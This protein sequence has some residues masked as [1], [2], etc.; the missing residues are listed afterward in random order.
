MR[1]DY[2]MKPVRVQRLLGRAAEGAE[3]QARCRWR[4]CRS[5]RPSR[6]RFLSVTER[7][8]VVLV[9]LD[10]IVYLKAELKYI[11]IRYGAAR[12]PARGSR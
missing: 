6:A 3:A 9:P 5:C 10:D 4:S 2:L 8:R 12:V 11:T 1:I 7:S